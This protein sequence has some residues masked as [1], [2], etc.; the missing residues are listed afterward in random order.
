MVALDTQIAT[1]VGAARTQPL[2]AHGLA[3]RRISLRG[4]EHAV[5]PAACCLRAQHHDLVSIEAIERPAES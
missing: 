4:G 1:M 2:A 5:R 3:E